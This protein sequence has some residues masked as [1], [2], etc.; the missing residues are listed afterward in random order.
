MGDSYKKEDDVLLELA[1]YDDLLAFRREVEEGCREIDGSGL[2]Y[3]RRMGPRKMG[4][5]ERTP[6][7]IAAMFGST[8]VLKYVI[9]SGKSDVNR[10]CGSDKATALHCAVSGG[11]A[12]SMEVVKLL[13]EASADADRVDG[14]GNKPI[15]VMAPPLRSRGCDSVRKGIEALLRGEQD[16][17]DSDSVVSNEEKVVFSGSPTKEGFEKEYPLDISLPDINN[18]IYSTDDFRMYAFKIKPCSRAYSHDWTECPFV[19]P[20]E[21]A[22]RRD[23]H[24]Y[25]YTCVPCPEFRKGLCP[26]GDSCEYA[27]GVFES[28][29]HPAQYRTR[30]CK[31]ETGCSRKVCFFAHKPE[32]LRPVYA[33]TGS[34]MPS[35]KSYSASGLDMSML[36]AISLGTSSPMSMPAAT[37]SPVMSPLAISTS[38]KNGNMM[39][40]WQNK[41]KVTP[42]SLQLSSSRLKAALSARDMDL[43]ME[44]LGLEPQ[45]ANRKQQQLMDEIS[46]LTSSPS[47]FSRMGELKPTNLDE[48]FIG[49]LDHSLISQLQLPSR[50]FTP[51]NQLQSPTGMQIRQNA[52]LQRSSYP[53]SIISS[54]ARKPTSSYGIDT[55]SAVATAVMNSRSSAFAKRS[56]SFI[57]RG[58]VNNASMMASNLNDWSSPGGKLD[59]GMQGDELNK[60]RKSA[61]M[62][63][64]SSNTPNTAYSGPAAEEPD[65]SWVS[66]LVKDASAAEEGMIFAEQNN[67]HPQYGYGKTAYEMMPPWGDQLYREPERMAA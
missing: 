17:S 31:D 51:T 49:S 25:P 64:R 22:R 5:E 57:D 52:N 53:A 58:A 6:L 37:S 11:S 9:E 47:S 60:L 4:L 15:D 61:S 3:G 1:A 33:S 62:R 13:L 38:S 55:S 12:S 50:P 43:E 40:S 20:G 44:L 45:A 7:M 65:L 48:M 66:S 32:E 36:S 14:S 56:Q 34:A 63:L 46:R 27:H 67:H 19:H 54:P 10:A 23:P 30:L 59:W 28:W 21:N 29:L 2:W 39:S 18:G 35:P 42:P 41:A 16:S 8:K 24:K 26:K